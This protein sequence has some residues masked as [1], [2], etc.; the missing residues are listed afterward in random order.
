[1]CEGRVRHL[2]SLFHPKYMELKKEEF[3]ACGDSHPVIAH[4]CRHVSESIR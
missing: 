4:Q 3:P 1:M 2:S